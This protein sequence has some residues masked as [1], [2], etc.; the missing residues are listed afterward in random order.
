MK[1]IT[2][3]YR[4]LVYKLHGVFLKTRQV[5]KLPVV[6]GLFKELVPEQMC[7]VYNNEYEKKSE[8]KAE[9]KAKAD[10]DTEIDYLDPVRNRKAFEVVLR[11]QTFGI[12]RL[13]ALDQLDEVGQRLAEFANT[14]TTDWPIP[15]LED[16]LTDYFEEYDR[17]RMDAD[18]R[19][20]KWFQINDASHDKWT[21]RQTL[22]DPDENGEWALFFEVDIPMSKKESRPVIKL[23]QIQNH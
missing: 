17:I 11:N 23:L 8:E 20:L 22:L 2:F 16:A 12:V 18:A 13:L 15:K 1:D 7:F 9:E 10:S 19:N 6:W 3:H 14:D 21:V 5:T 4:P